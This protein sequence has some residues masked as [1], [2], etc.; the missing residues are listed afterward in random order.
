M[1]IPYD[2][3]EHLHDPDMRFNFNVLVSRR[4]AKFSIAILNGTCRWGEM[5]SRGP[6]PGG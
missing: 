5:P 1:T 6:S 4:G 2:S 3:L